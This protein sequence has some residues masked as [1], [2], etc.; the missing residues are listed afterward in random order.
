MNFKAPF[1]LNDEL[2]LSLEGAKSNLWA[3]FQHII[4]NLIYLIYIEYYH[5]R[6]ID[7][8]SALFPCPGIHFLNLL[9]FLVVVSCR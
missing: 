5:M 6:S 2:L 4:K 7:I 9:L 3:L 8:I 1:D